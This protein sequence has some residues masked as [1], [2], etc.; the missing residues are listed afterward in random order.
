LTGTFKTALGG[1]VATR[2]RYRVPGCGGLSG[3]R[4]RAVA[5]GIVMDMGRAEEDAQAAGR[6]WQGTD[7]SAYQFDDLPSAWL[8]GLEHLGL[9]PREGAAPPAK[10]AG[11]LLLREGMAL[12]ARR[13]AEPADL[14]EHGRS[15]SRL[16]RATRA[17]RGLWRV[18]P[19]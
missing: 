5:A 19:N 6:L 4:R 9:R 12:A 18:E 10:A 1:W 13:I 3:A 11:L 7:I 17:V 15:L 14:R 16:V 8:A 2:R